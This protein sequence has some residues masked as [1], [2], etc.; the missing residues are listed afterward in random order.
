MDKGRCRFLNNLCVLMR[1]A[2][3]LLLFTPV[4]S[5]FPQPLQREFNDDEGKA[6]DQIGKVYSSEDGQIIVLFGPW[7]SGKSTLISSMIEK[8]SDFTDLTTLIPPSLTTP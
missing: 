6:A 5:D 3:R 1:D 2:F 4:K 8:V 7:G